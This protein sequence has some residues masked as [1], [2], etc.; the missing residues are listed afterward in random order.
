MKASR[1]TTSKTAILDLIKRSPSALSHVEIQKILNG[2]CD[3]VTIYRVLD[4]LIADDLIHKI[5]T[6]D[7]TLKYAACRHL[8]CKTKP[9]MHQHIHFSCEKCLQVTCIDDANPVFELPKNYFVKDV[10]FTIS[11]LCPDCI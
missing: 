2:I 1:N 9:D 3:R 4:R 5:A 10:N 7:G 6:P 8:H 11:G